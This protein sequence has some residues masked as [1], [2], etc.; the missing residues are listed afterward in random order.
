MAVAERAALDVLACQADAD[1]VGEDGGKRQLL[2]G[3]PVDRHARQHCRTYGRF[4]RT[5]SSLRWMTN[6]AGRREQRLVHLAQLSIG[7]AVSAFAAAP[8]GGGSG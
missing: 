5:R 1:A 4:S 8:G 2:G 6:S 3:R 7:T